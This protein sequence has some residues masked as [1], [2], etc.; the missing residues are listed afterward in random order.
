M[1]APPAGATSSISSA[2]IDRSKVRILAFLNIAGDGM[3]DAESEQN[4]GGPASRR[5]PPRGAR[6]IRSSSSASRPPT[7]GRSCPGTQTHP[8]WA[9]VERAVEAGELCRHAGHGGLLAAPAE[10]PYP[11][12]ILKKLRPGDI[13][14]HVFAQ[15]FP[16]LDGHGKVYDHM[17]E[18]RERG[19]IFDLGHGAGS[20]WFRNAVPGLPRAASARLDHHR[21][22]HG[23]RQRPGA[24][25]ARRPCPNA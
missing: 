3:V 20:F 6:P 1:R 14:T 12:L 5:S 4:V 22:P 2:G 17:F 19:V 9:S 21:L 13:H 18:A 25:H 23:Q 16:I 11:D 8:P 15:Q 24:E 7:T 10:R